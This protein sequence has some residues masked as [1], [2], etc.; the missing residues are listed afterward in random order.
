MPWKVQ[1]AWLLRMKNCKTKIGEWSVVK[2]DLYIQRFQQVGTISSTT[3]FH[4][5][6]FF[7]FDQQP[8]FMIFVNLYI[9]HILESW[10]S[11]GFKSVVYTNAFPKKL[12]LKASP[13]FKVLHFWTFLFKISPFLA[14]SRCVKYGATCIVKIFPSLSHIWD[15]VTFV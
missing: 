2:G 3:P 5:L 15:V 7:A 11:P 1:D 6:S 12:I 9:F 10:G 8:E 13:V 4:S 14:L